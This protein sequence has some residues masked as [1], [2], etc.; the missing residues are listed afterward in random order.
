MGVFAGHGGPTGHVGGVMRSGRPGRRRCFRRQ[1]AGFVALGQ[2]LDGEIR[3][4][5]LAQAAADAVESLD[6]RVVRQQQA[7]LGADL[8]ADVAALAPLVDPADVDEV[9]GRGRSARS[10]L[11]GVRGSRGSLRGITASS[12]MDAGS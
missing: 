9:D 3:A 5:A 6:D 11:G 7:V 2:D 4:V 10:A 8:D 12:N 1:A